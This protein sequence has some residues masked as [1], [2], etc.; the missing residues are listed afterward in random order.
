M[1]I[2]LKFQDLI[3]LA[4]RSEYSRNALFSK[5]KNLRLATA[6][7]N[8]GDKFAEMMDTEGHAFEFNANHHGDISDDE[9]DD[10]TNGEFSDG[11][12]NGSDGEDD[13]TASKESTLDESKGFPVRKEG[14]HLDLADLA[15]KNVSISPAYTKGIMTWLKRIQVESRGFELGTFKASLLGITMKEQSQKW[16]SLALGYISDV[17]MLVHT[18]FTDLLGEVTP[19]EGMRCSVESMLVEELRKRYG[20]AISHTEF[21]LKVELESNPATHNHYFNENLEKWCDLCS[22]YLAACD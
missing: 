7:I 13:R 10:E 5:H 11:S 20:A 4:V 22:S 21:L 3:S 12:E 16:P 17:V 1:G 15:F 14:D 18:V 19:N 9:S 2:A 6:V 8:R